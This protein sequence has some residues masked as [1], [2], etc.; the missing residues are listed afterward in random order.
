MEVTTTLVLVLV[1]ATL[2][3]AVAATAM[4]SPVVATC[5]NVRWSGMESEWGWEPETD[6]GRSTLTRNARSVGREKGASV[7]AMEAMLAL[8]SAPAPVH[9]QEPELVVGTR[10]ASSTTG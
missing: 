2:T 7:G 1:E 4:L 6:Q 3:P 9:G 10:A 8:A 5:S